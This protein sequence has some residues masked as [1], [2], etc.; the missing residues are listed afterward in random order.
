MIIRTDIASQPTTSCRG[1]A[2]IIR[3]VMASLVLVIIVCAM[4]SCS[5]HRHVMYKGQDM[6]E[7]VRAANRLG[8]PIEADDDWALMI[9]VSTWIGTPYR[10]GGNTRAGVDCSGFT[11]YIY[12]KVYGKQLHRRSADQY[13]LDCRPV[14]QSKLRQGD[15][16]FFDTSSASASKDRKS[17]KSAPNINHTGIYLRDGMFIH[18]SSHGVMVDRLS[19][20]YYQ[21]TWVDGGR[22]K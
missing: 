12:N 22:V 8:F 5:S 3:I 9:E 2:D 13:L 1:V 17:S 15:L 14:K 16:V 19:S 7:L 20:T 6:N 11:S 18:A 4:P 10:Q 21:R